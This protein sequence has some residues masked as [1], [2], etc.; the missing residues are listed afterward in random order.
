LAP[1]KSSSFSTFPRTDSFRGVGGSKRLFGRFFSGPPHAYFPPFRRSRKLSFV[2]THVF[3][4]NLRASVYFPPSRHL[5]PYRRSPPSHFYP[6]LGVFTPPSPHALEGFAP[7]F[8]S[9]PFR[10]D[11]ERI[12]NP[13]LSPLSAEVQEVSDVWSVTLSADIVFSARFHPYQCS[14]PWN[15]PIP[16]P[17]R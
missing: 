10:H 14:L 7:A 3:S 6:R 15:R 16:R 2:L 9:P 1:L 17:D 8:Q 4:F 12:P 11:L 13:F 5:G